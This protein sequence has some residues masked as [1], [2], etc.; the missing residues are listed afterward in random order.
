MKLSRSATGLKKGGTHF[1]K[2][3]TYAFA[4]YFG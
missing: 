3:N 2:P 4:L 1:F